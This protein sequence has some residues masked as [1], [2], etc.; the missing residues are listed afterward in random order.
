MKYLLLILGL[1][2]LVGCTQKGINSPPD[3]RSAPYNYLEQHITNL[4]CDVNIA[5][6]TDLECWK[7]PDKPLACVDKN[8]C[9]WYCHQENCEVLESYP[10]QLRC[11]N[12]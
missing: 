11:G 1:F 2:L 10:P 4:K 12:N 6:P 3:D 7:L 9:V 8:P 5:C